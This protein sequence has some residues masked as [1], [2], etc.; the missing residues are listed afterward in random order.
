[1]QMEKH[2][3]TIKS[4]LIISVH[5]LTGIYLHYVQLMHLFSPKW[6]RYHEL[7]IRY[8]FAIIIDAF[9]IIMIILISKQP[10]KDQGI[11]HFAG[12]TTY[13]FHFILHF[14]LCLIIGSKPGLSELLFLL[15]ITL[16]RW[17]LFRFHRYI[18][19]KRGAVHV[20]QNYDH[21]AAV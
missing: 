9:I 14:V 10:V 12:I 11:C 17:L 7:L 8:L 15:I 20:C 18:D 2:Y 4:V 5:F 3:S 16:Y 19:W 13:Y 6:F 21:G 1:M